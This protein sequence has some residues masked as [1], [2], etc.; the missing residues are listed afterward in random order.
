MIY[1]SSARMI[2]NKP[3]YLWSEE[4]EYDLPASAR[5]PPRWK[6][7]E[8]GLFALS[9]PDSPEELLLLLS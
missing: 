1:V 8:A 5:D 6:L 2:G 7:P 4:D 3:A 9:L